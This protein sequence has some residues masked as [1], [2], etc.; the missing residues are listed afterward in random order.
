MKGRVLIVDD[1]PA[2]CELVHAGITPLGYEVAWEL[3]AGS[4]LARLA[5]AEFDVV[6]TDLRMQ[7]MSGVELC[8]E[9]AEHRPGLPVVV[10][11]AFGS[12]D[13]AVDAIRAGAYD[14]VSKPIELDALELVIARAVEHRRLS[15]E[16]HML[17][18]RARE[19]PTAPGIVGD[20]VAMRRVLELI[21]RV[22]SADVPVLVTGETGTGKELVARAVHGASAGPEGPFVPVNCAAIPAALLESE[23]FGHVKGAFTDARRARQG[24]FAQ[25]RGGTLFLDEVG[26]IGLE[27]QPKLLRAL[28]ER[29]VRPVGSDTEVEISCRILAAT[30][31]DL[32][33]AA[34][35]GSFRSD[36]YY[37]L[38]VIRVRL[39]PLRTRAGDILLLAQ[40]FI[41]DAVSR[42]GR[43]VTG[44]TTPVA[45][46]LLAYDWP[47]N[48]RELEN[49]V[50]RAVALTLHDRLVL[51]DLPE[52]IRLRPAPE[53]RM[54]DDD[55][56]RLASL[57]EVS[58]R[59]VLKVLDAVDGN[60]SLAAQILGVD[61]RTLYR[62]LE[63]LEGPDRRSLD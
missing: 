43:G 11:T 62:K 42:S 20:S 28:Q 22:A 1:E 5:S 8:A 9:V 16:L 29:R 12:L 4:A 10:L 23:L 45:R 49:C 21:P 40:R 24:L 52:E 26:E 38:A 63:R 39:P 48:V 14:F 57:A 7:G 18:R 31:R 59:H 60:K 3:D 17:R 50:E 55:P 36:L 61:R 27:L 46:A 2:M 56:G 19:T 47:G 35:Q 33:R 13:A 6:L 51:D 44:M 34:E 53:D 54:G 58:R 32:R 25:A 41:D 15:Q 37:R 30:N